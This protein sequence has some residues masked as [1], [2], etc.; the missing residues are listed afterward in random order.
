MLVE[1][2]MAEEKEKKHKE[3]FGRPTKYN[4]EIAKLICERIATHDCGIQRLCDMYEDMPDKSTIRL[5]KLKHIDFSSQYADAKRQQVEN[6]AEDIIDISDD[7]IQDYG[8]DEDG[9]PV[10]R[11]DH[12]QR[13][14][15]RVDSRKWMASKLAPKIY[16]DK[17]IIEQTTTE[18]DQLKAELATLRMQLDKKNKSSY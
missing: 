2:I 12:V 15:L 9:N 11:S 8:Y 13:A 3:P 6:F 7:G 5:W 4:P 1:V 17:Q 10:F 16:G 18:N 14:R